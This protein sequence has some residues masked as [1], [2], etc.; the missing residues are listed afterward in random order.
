[1]DTMSSAQMTTNVIW[2]VAYVFFIIVFLH[3]LTI[4]LFF[5]S[6]GSYLLILMLHN[7]Q[8]QPPLFPVPYAAAVSICSQGHNRHCFWTATLR[9]PHHASPPPYLQATARRGSWRCWQWWKPWQGMPTNANNNANEHQHQHQWMPTPTNANA[10]KH[11]GNEQR[12]RQMNRGATNPIWGNDKWIV[13]TT[14]WGWQCGNTQQRGTTTTTNTTMAWPHSHYK[15]ETMGLF[16]FLFLIILFS[17]NKQPVTATSTCL[18]G[19]M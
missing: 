3:L 1:M 15:H 6:F 4:T 14:T 8:L 10:N 17:F 16:F 18:W 2:A 19:V 9:M 13:G 5:L 7:C 11:Q 12:A